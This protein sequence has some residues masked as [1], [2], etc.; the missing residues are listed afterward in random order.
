MYVLASYTNEDFISYSLSFDKTAIP[1]G[2]FSAVGIRGIYS[3]V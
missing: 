2:I 3:S 1:Q